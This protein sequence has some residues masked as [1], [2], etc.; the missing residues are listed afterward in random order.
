MSSTFSGQPE[1]S[2]EAPPEVVIQVS[3]VSKAYRIWRNPADRLKYPLLRALGSIL[4]RFLQPPQLRRR[5]GTDQA[6]RY[7][8][9]FKAL[10]DV[11]L[12]VR[13]GETL[14]IVGRNGSGKSTLLQIICGTLTPT[15]G[16]VAVRGKV[17][18]LLELGSGF[19]PEFTGRENVYLN[20]AVLGLERAQIDARLAAI[21]EFADIGTFLDQPVKTYSSG[22]YVRLAF[23]IITQ[24]DADILVID[25]ALAVG[26]AFFTQKCMR[27][28]RQFMES[29]TIIF[30]SHDTGAVINLCRSAVW[31]E[32]GHVMREGEPKEIA[33]AYLANFYEANQ[34]ASK[35]PV[36]TTSAPAVAVRPP[37]RD[38]RMEFINRS[39]QRNDIEVFRF[40]DEADSFGLGGASIVAVDLGDAQGA[41]LSWIVGGEQVS[42]TVACFAR[43]ELHRPI[44]GFFIKDR[45]GQTLFGDNTF[46]TYLGRPISITA[47]SSFQ[48]KFVFA[49]P[50][51]PLGDYSV[52]V[53]L[54]EGTQEDH[55][56]HHWIHDAIFFKSH[57][58]STC[59]GLVGIPMQSIEIL[60]N[61][62]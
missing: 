47:N 1:P 51:L 39:A 37:E 5:I 32:R 6:T 59:T 44:V 17:A 27:F 12:T 40:R 36:P 56:Q 24:V 25:E 11:S 18:A 33:A 28:L 48:A 15:S 30:V 20:G 23:A 61:D 16:T 35:L 34:G 46:L 14:G 53:A 7:Y 29:G 19:N 2:P 8:T 10:D 9:D 55:V 31:L 3:R 62:L 57:S 54:A 43:Q 26:D 38:Q 49:M 41:P 58:S 52:C 42:L 13:K 45:L 60:T 22:M 50:L 4:P 21:A